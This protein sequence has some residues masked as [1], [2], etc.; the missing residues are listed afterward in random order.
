[1]PN[2]LSRVTI[3]IVLATRALS[4]PDDHPSHTGYLVNHKLSPGW[5]E[6]RLVLSP[7]PRILTLTIFFNDLPL[8]DAGG[9][10]HQTRSLFKQLITY[11]ARRRSDLLDSRDIPAAHSSPRQTPT[12]TPALAHDIFTS[13]EG[14]EADT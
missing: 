10:N 2:L 5:R 3:S 14:R 4:F 11:H 12:P 7:H 6:Y 1:M 13:G 8:I 9:H